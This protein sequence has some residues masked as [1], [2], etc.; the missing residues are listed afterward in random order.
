MAVRSNPFSSRARRI[1]ATRPS[2]MSEGATTSTPALACDSA[3]FARSG[4]VASLSTSPSRITPQWPCEVNSSRQTSVT[5]RICGTSFFSRRTV[6][7]TAAPSSQASLPISS[8]LSGIPKRMTAGTP[9]ERSS[10]ASATASSGERRE[11]PGREEIGCRRP[12]PWRTKNPATKRSAERRVSRTSARRAGER[13]SRRRRRIGNPVTAGNLCPRGRRRKSFE[14]RHG[15]AETRLPGHLDARDAV[16]LQK[17]PREPAQDDGGSGLQAPRGGLSQ[18]IEEPAS[19]RG[20]CRAERREGFLEDLALEAGFARPWNFPVKN[21]ASKVR[22]SGAQ[23]LGK[24]GVGVFAAGQQESPPGE[25]P[26]EPIEN[27]LSGTVGHEVRPDSPGRQRFR[28]HRPDGHHAAAQYRG[29]EEGGSARVR[30][31][32]LHRDLAGEDREFRRDFEKNV[33]R[34]YRLDGMARLLE[35]LDT[36]AWRQRD[37]GVRP[38][39]HDESSRQTHRLAASISAAAPR[40]RS[41]RPTSRPIETA[42]DAG[43]RNFSRSALDP[44]GENTPAESVRD[45]SLT[46]ARPAT[47]ALHPAS[48]VESRLRSA[49]ASWC[50]APSSSASRRVSVA[51]SSPRA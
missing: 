39:A 7:W 13:R 15:L 27:T 46:R 48:S 37:E 50:E 14:E 1:A 23:T 28:R 40:S 51:R 12:F 47:G 29:A 4:S 33:A 31:E 38:R 21:Q 26:R 42:S 5:T 49:K 2:I 24:L 18:A 11:T 19:S 25:I 16:R 10:C 32:S 20:G 43:P 8:F 6:S 22:A 30:E 45:P 41:F 36:G 9:S 17:P 44:S 34:L 35:D 3:A